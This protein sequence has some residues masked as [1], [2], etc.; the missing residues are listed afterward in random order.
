MSHRSF[1][2]RIL[3]LAVSGLAL[4]VGVSP[5][6]A[7]WAAAPPVLGSEVYEGFDLDRLAK[8]LARLTTLRTEHGEREGNEAFERWLGGQGSSRAAYETA[9]AAWY[10]RFRADSSGKL[11]ARFHS[12]NSRYVTEENFADAPDRSREVRGGL[13]LD[14]YAQIAVALTRPPGADMK[15]VLAKF[16]LKSEAE[17]TKA[18]NAWVAEMR[19][20][21][22]F[23]LTQQYGALYQKYAGPEFEQETEAK[24]AESLAGRFE[25]EQPRPLDPPAPPTIDDYLADLRA[26]LPSK[27]WEAARGYAHQCDLWAGPARKP[28]KDPRAPHCSPAVLKRD[29][30]PIILDA[31]DHF[32]DSTISRATGLL[33]FLDELALETPDGK[34]TVQRAKNR[35]QARLAMLEAAFAP[36]RDKAVPERLVLRSRIDDYTGAIRDFDRALARW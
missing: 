1:S 15:K 5:P 10:E 25:K 2:I 20:D 31:I 33:D 8:A 22:T 29:L 36:I 30:L 28:A 3:C 11:E 24:V 27:R 17:W 14:R 4:G 7:A 21:T 13:T 16:G 23:A 12:L 9:Y 18:T 26:D 6:R 35:C 32:D 19:A 34:L